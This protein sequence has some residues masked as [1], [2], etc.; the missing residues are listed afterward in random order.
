MGILLPHIKYK[1]LLGSLCNYNSEAC[2]P[3]V[4]VQC[5]HETVIRMGDGVIFA[6]IYIY[7]TEKHAHSMRTFH[8]QKDILS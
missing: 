5:K 3:V 2:W 6:Y 8:F 1:G 4:H 7:I